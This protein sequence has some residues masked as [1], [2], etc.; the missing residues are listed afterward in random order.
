MAEDGRKDGVAKLVDAQAGG[1]RE[2]D[3]RL[4]IMYHCIITFTF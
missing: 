4:C 2:E 3:E 1:N